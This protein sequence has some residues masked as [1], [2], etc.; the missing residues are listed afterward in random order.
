MPMPDQNAFFMSHHAR[1]CL[2][3][4]LALVVLAAGAASVGADESQ[5]RQITF[6]SSADGTQQPAWLILPEPFDAA[7][8]PVPLLVALH[9]WSG[10][11]E[12]RHKGLEKAAQQRG[13]IYLFPHFRGVNNR[14]EACG[15]LLAQQDIL[16]AVAWTRR[17]YPVDAR[18]IYL[19]GSSGGGHMA[20][21]MAGRHPQLWAGVS[22]W[23]GIS[24]L[25]AWHA[26]HAETR[27][28][29]MLRACCGGAPG[30][31]PEV[32]EQ[33]RARSPNTWI[34][35]AVDVPLDL[36]AGIHDGHTG[37]VPIHHTLDA[38]NLV[39]RAQGLPEVSPEEIEQLSRPDGRL[40]EPL[41]SD[42]QPD[43]DY[44]RAIHLRRTAGKARVTIFE[45][46]HE[47][48]DDA[49]IAWLSRQAKPVD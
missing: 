5:R 2:S 17:H 12:Q 15:S 32:D 13:W 43:E 9:S 27:Y 22:A 30:D 3:V 29:A 42:L 49:A 35:G 34:A 39:A 48:L 33:Y 37:S 31:S 11:M 36:A 46:G 38:F 6:V 18:R 1:R 7:G 47:R 24:D 25:A 45:G 41:P 19:T 21:L 26:M 14:P 4:A 16:D 28:G 10:G 23:V 44:S 40:K 20:M 8:P